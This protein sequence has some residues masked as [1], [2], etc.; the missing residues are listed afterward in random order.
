MANN[1]ILS[2]L[3]FL[4]GIS[5]IANIFDAGIIEFEAHEHYSKGSYRNRCY[6]A[7]ANGKALLSIPLAKGKNQ[8]M[9]VRDVRIIY[10]IDWQS[11]YWKTIKTAYNRSPFFE[12]YADQLLPFFQKK[13]PFLFDYN[14][15]LFYTLHKIMALKGVI[16]LTESYKKVSEG[17]KKDLRNIF[18][19][20]QTEVFTSAQPYTQVFADRLPFIPGLSVLDLIFCKGPASGDYLKKI[21]QTISTN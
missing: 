6:I 17:G 15:D 4:P 20:N 10:D 19:P 14:L 8:Q 13:Y 16:K 18:R 7:T 9:P 5:F 1:H 3:H 12:Y 2:E 11:L 21:N